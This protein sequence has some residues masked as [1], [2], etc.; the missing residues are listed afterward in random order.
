MS[1]P[2][3][4]ATALVSVEPSTSIIVVRASPWNRL[5]SAG[6]SAELCRKVSCSK[7]PVHCGCRVR[8]RKVHGIATKAT[9][10]AA[11]GGG[12]QSKEGQN[13]TGSPVTA[14]SIIVAEAP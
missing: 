1:Q 6:S 2:L 8:I 10:R 5:A 11:T 9:R 14:G 12:G 13:H 4:W 7:A 3:R